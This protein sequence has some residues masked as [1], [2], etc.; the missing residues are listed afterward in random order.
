MADDRYTEQ[1]AADELAHK[2]DLAE[3]FLR[4]GDEE[5]LGTLMLLSTPEEIG[6]DPE[7]YAQDLLGLP[8]ARVRVPQTGVWPRWADGRERARRG[9][10]RD[11]R[12]SDSIVIQSADPAGGQTWN[13]A[14]ESH[15]QNIGQ[16]WPPRGSS[17]KRDIPEAA[18]TRHLRGPYERGADRGTLVPVRLPSDVRPDPSRPY[19]DRA[20]GGFGWDFYDELR[21]KYP[22]IREWEQIEKDSWEGA[23]QVADFMS[24]PEKREALNTW[25]GA[26]QQYGEDMQ[27]LSS[28]EHISAMRLEEMAW[29]KPVRDTSGEVI[30]IVHRPTSRPDS[31]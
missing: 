4:D 3:R 23:Q 17:I 16:D 26:K 15:I 24:D 30:G 29:E 19:I 1:T 8:A 9:I 27:R 13:E 7:Q 28:D 25:Y 11:A 6:G 22:A 31:D 5:A 2:K 14:R 21:D 10:E 18:V 12:E 20:D